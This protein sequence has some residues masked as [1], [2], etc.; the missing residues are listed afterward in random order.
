[1]RANCF[2]CGY[3][4]SW[5]L[6]SSGQTG[7]I[8]FALRRSATMASNLIEVAQDYPRPIAYWYDRFMRA[9]R[10][11]DPFAMEKYYLALHESTLCYLAMICLSQY[12][13]DRASSVGDPELDRILARVL[14]NRKYS[15]GDYHQ[16]VNHLVGY[17]CQQP[18]A[19]PLIELLDV[20]Y[21]PCG[22]E[23]SL[24]DYFARVV[25]IRNNL[26]HIPPEEPPLVLDRMRHLRAELVQDLLPVL[27]FVRRY[28]LLAAT[29]ERY[30]NRERYA[31]EFD[32][33]MGTGQAVMGPERRV[34]LPDWASIPVLFLDLQ[35]RCPASYLP[36]YPLYNYRQDE[37]D[38]ERL[39]LEYV[40]RAVTNRNQTGLKSVTFTPLHGDRSS[41]ICLGGE[42]EQLLKGFERRIG[43]LLAA[44]AMNPDCGPQL[45]WSEDDYLEYGFPAADAFIRERTRLFVGREALMQE[46][47]EAVD[48]ADGQYHAIVAKPGTGKSAVLARLLTMQKY[49]GDADARFVQHFVGPGNG[50]RRLCPMLRWLCA[51]L[52]RQNDYAQRDNRPLDFRA[53]IPRDDLDQALETAIYKRAR[54]KWPLVIV[55]DGLNELEE[56]ARNLAWLPERLPANVTVLLATCP[57]S[58]VDRGLARLGTRRHTLEPLDSRAAAEL[59]KRVLAES[60]TPQMV[61]HSVCETLVAQA[62]GNP[63]F[64]K[65]ASR[66]LR[67]VADDDWEP[68]DELTDALG[69]LLKLCLRNF[70]KQPV[71]VLVQ[72]LAVSPEGLPD[73]ELAVLLASLSDKQRQKLLNELRPFVVLRD[74]MF[75][76]FHTNFV[77]AVRQEFLDEK[78]IRRAHRRLAEFYRNRCREGWNYRRSLRYLPYHLHQAGE[79][80]QLAELLSDRSVIA[81]AFDFDMIEDHV[82][83][84]RLLGKPKHLRQAAQALVDSLARSARGVMHNKTAHQLRWAL[85]R[86]FGPF[87]AWPEELRQSF[88]QTDNP[89][90]LIF[91]AN[92]L[93]MAGDFDAAEQYYRAVVAQSAGDKD[94]PRLYCEAC[95]SLAMVLGHLGRYDEGLGILDQ[96]IREEDAEARYGLQYWRARYHRGILLRQCERYAEALEEFE[97]IRLGAA[98]DR[99]A[100]G[101]VHQAAV[102]HLE[103]GDFPEAE[104]LLLQ[105]LKLR[106]KKA[107][108]HRLAHD[109]RR[110]GQLAAL[111]G[112]L[113]RARQQFELAHEVS[114]RCGDF[115][116]VRRIAQDVRTFVEVPARWKDEKRERIELPVEEFKEIQDSKKRFAMQ[117]AAFRVMA[118]IQP[119]Y[120]E[121][122]DGSTGETTDQAAAWDIVHGGPVWHRTVSVLA[123]SPN[124]QVAIQRRTERD[125]YGK[126]D[127]SASGH[128]GV[129]ERDTIAAARE[130][131]EEMGFCVTPDRLQ[132]CFASYR[133]RKRG[134]PDLQPDYSEDGFTYTYRTDKHNC[135]T[136][137]VFM[138]LISAEERA[139]IDRHLGDHVDWVLWPDLVAAAQETDQY[140]SAVKQLCHERVADQIQHWIDGFDGSL[141][142]TACSAGT[143]PRVE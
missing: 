103:L 17:Y 91:L 59:M 130:M 60:P 96:R 132:A 9:V 123:V 126:W 66:Y 134:G 46:L 43:P 47:T 65:V 39:E 40:T 99:L 83:S 34:P 109:Y 113:P 18:E 62:A 73:E 120:L 33:L 19:F 41:P 58:L 12:M 15:M 56:D 44:A 69:R 10:K 102:V 70:R 30:E 71:K 81:A 116:Y 115:Q 4:V 51:Q 119:E 101:V 82:R 133:F 117:R 86:C 108:N 35:T 128:V 143:D 125:S 5:K 136:V 57:D 78:Q 22:Q 100:P 94:R 1:M 90:A 79:Y 50:S 127:V 7:A 16:I 72:S 37:R 54:Q 67:Q 135:E 20:W 63:L 137:S 13:E 141:S 52:Y 38:Y 142:D 21:G 110:L 3:K 2:R 122:A 139:G 121:I 138:L 77:H 28:P 68:T 112:D 32:C 88:T 87:V 76:F 26:V 11:Q 49:E 8:R 27:A 114:V 92:V 24:H 89:S 61:P 42:Q 14:L 53:R 31:C 36:L 140:A 84:L 131:C 95:V 93:D 85:H 111:Q 124:R 98:G 107:D 6:P 29:A 80:R 25:R 74:R 75:T 129:G 97:S 48:R 23:A 45:A 55:I 104:R 106:S 64:L 105:A 118:A